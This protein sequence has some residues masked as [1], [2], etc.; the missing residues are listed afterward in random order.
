MSVRRSALYSSYVLFVFS[1]IRLRVSHVIGSFDE[2]TP[3]YT[4]CVTFCHAM[5]REAM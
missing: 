4:L 3:V 2:R 5:Y 1:I